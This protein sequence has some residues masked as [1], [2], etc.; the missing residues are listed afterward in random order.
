MQLGRFD[1]HAWPQ[2]PQLSV[3]SATLTQRPPHTVR[4]REQQ[5]PSKHSSVP[6]QE[7][8]HLPQWRLLKTRLKHASSH[9]VS[10]AAH[11]TPH[12]ELTQAAVAGREPRSAALGAT[13]G[14]HTRPQLPQFRTSVARSAEQH[15]E[16]WHPP[17]PGG[18]TTEPESPGT[19]GSALET[20]PPSVSSCGAP[21]PPRAQPEAETR[22]G[23]V[24]R[25]ASIPSR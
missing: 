24:A 19:D 16:P 23:R 12:R 3:E 4:P 8:P 1:G 9:L 21:S 13:G 18:A 22:G 25:N 5:T 7:L 11:A 15:D 20:R 10:P 14:A 6:A 2:A 17:S